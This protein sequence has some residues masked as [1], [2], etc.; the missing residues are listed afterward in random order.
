MKI[1]AYDLD[2]GLLPRTRSASVCK[3]V[4]VGLRMSIYRYIN[5]CGPK[6]INLNCT[7]VIDS[8][9]QTFAIE[10]IIEFID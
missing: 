2:E 3:V 1:F 7:L 9:F 10:L 5:I 6:K 8:P 4:G